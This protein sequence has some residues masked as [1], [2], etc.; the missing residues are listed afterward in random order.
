M[1]GGCP[2]GQF[3]SGCSSS[4]PGMCVDCPISTFAS[5]FGKRASCTLCSSC[6]AG[7]TVA[8][9]CT[10]DADVKCQENQCL[11]CASGT[12]LT[13]CDV[14]AGAL[15]Q[16]ESCA[17]CGADK[18]ISGCGGGSAGVCEDCPGNMVSP[19]GTRALADCKCIVG[20]APA[21]SGSQCEPCPAG[22]YK[23]SAGT[24]GCVNCE[25][26]KFSTAQNASTCGQCSGEC[27]VGQEQSV[28][29]AGVQDRTCSPCS[30]GL[31]PS[32][33][34]FTLANDCSRWECMEGYVSRPTP[35]G[36]FRSRCVRPSPTSVASVATVQ[37]KMVLKLSATEVRRSEEVLV[38]AFSTLSGE[39]SG[40]IFLLA[41][42][43]ASTLRTQENS[44]GG[45]RLG[46]RG[47]G[48][49]ARA[50]PTSGSGGGGGDGGEVST[51]GLT[52]AVGGRGAGGA[53]GAGGD[54]GAGEYAWWLR[55]EV[56][57]VMGVRTVS[58]NRVQ[59]TMSLSAVNQKLRDLGLPEARHMELR[60]YSG[61]L[62]TTGVAALNN[63]ASNGR[64]DP[65]SSAAASSNSPATDP[66]DKGVSVAAIAGGVAGGCAALLVVAYLLRSG[67]KRPTPP[68]P[69]SNG[70]HQA[71]V[72]VGAKTRHDVLNP[73]W[74][75]VQ[76]LKELQDKNIPMPSQYSRPHLT[77]W[78]A[79]GGVAR[80]GGVGREAAAPNGG[81]GKRTVQDLRAKRAALVQTVRNSSALVSGVV[82]GPSSEP[83]L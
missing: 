67:S 48:G 61:D 60:S 74:A 63:N 18:Y 77:A 25:A 76:K 81:G 5:G 70:T 23:S 20:F 69:N 13:G 4:S 64:K 9:S 68:E 30:P 71:T 19:A 16:C 33:A 26:G 52:V 10:R 72:S 1:C 53:R 43:D 3:R 45:G 27:A 11:T 40:N 6:P 78:N 55:S 12:Y 35:E 39:D 80:G 17:T 37:V 44:W 79:G 21:S 24:G 73:Y 51:R 14:L 57:A 75:E 41:I 15:G 59:Q 83:Q 28:P 34:R 32:N 29:C 66:D 65:A 56:V 7:Q 50:R 82:V 46:G 2:A 31:K 62:A 36:A 47:G 38:S 58:P 42:E 22:T 8:T 54:G 49:G